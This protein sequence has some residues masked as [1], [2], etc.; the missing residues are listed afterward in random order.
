MNIEFLEAVVAQ[1]SLKKVLKEDRRRY[2]SVV[3]DN[4]ALHL[5]E[6]QSNLLNTGPESE[7]EEVNYH[8]PGSSTPATESQ[9]LNQR[10]LPERGLHPKQLFEGFTK[11]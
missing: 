7:H 11:D 4:E 5:V 8:S 9:K 3:K 6:A 1:S 2:T 10:M